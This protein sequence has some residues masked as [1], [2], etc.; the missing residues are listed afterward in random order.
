MEIFLSE[1]TN[2]TSESKGY[3]IK[4][5]KPK[6]LYK[7]THALILQIMKYLQGG[8]TTQVD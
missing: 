6:L 5:A 2:H 1:R 4:F 7:D 8:I 3:Q